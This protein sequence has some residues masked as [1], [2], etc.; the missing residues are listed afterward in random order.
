MSIAAVTLS[1]PLIKM[2]HETVLSMVPDRP[3]I[4]GVTLLVEEYAEG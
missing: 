3:V 1:F 2:K 4:V